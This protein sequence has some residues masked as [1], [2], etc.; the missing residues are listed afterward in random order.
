MRPSLYLLCVAVLTGLLAW[1][2][3]APSQTR[4]NLSQAKSSVITAGFG[5]L[6]DSASADATLRILKVN[7][8]EIMHRVSVP[9]PGTVCL[10]RGAMAVESTAL[11]FCI[12]ND[13]PVPP[14]TPGLPGRW[15]KFPQTSIAVYNHPSGLI[16]ADLGPL[17]IIGTVATPAQLN[18]PNWIPQP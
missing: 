9:V 4:I 7:T 6:L 14:G 3:P 17:S 18:A 13:S 16:R 10:I 15:V 8:S 1:L 2:L 12:M 5:L 11:Y